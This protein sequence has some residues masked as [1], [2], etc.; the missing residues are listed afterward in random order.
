MAWPEAT[1]GPAAGS[2]PLLP[3]AKD[4]HRLGNILDRLWAEIVE[5]ALKLRLT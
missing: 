5:F 3:D 1:K 2:S 4:M